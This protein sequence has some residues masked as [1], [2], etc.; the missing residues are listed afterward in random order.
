MDSFERQM[1]IDKLQAIVSGLD[2]DEKIFG[3]TGEDL[4]RRAKYQ[5]RIKELTQPK[6]PAQGNEDD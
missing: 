2:E 4:E 3:L 1:E 5:A 6:Q